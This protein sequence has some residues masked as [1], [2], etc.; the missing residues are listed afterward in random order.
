[1]WRIASEQSR[2]SDLFCMWWEWHCQLDQPILQMPWFLQGGLVILT[3]SPFKDHNRNSVGEKWRI[4]PGRINKSANQWAAL[5]SPKGFWWCCTL[6]ALLG[7]SGMRISQGSVF[8]ISGSERRHANRKSIWW[9]IFNLQGKVLCKLWPAAS[10]VIQLSPWILWNL[11]Q[12]G[13]MLDR[14][15]WV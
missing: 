1:M 4:L 3:I 13:H 11:G 15:M 7:A 12:I 8:Q 2:I 6:M 9:V 14:Y 5:L 10:S